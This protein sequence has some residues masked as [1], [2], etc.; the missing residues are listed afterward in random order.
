MYFALSFLQ[1]VLVN[2][3]ALFRKKMLECGEPVQLLLQRQVS[4]YVFLN[5]F[6]TWSAIAKMNWLEHEWEILL[7]LQETTHSSP[8]RVSYGMSSV[9]ML[10]TIN[11]DDVWYQ[12][13]IQRSEWKLCFCSSTDI[14]S[15][16]LFIDYPCH[17]TQNILRNQGHGY[18]YW[19]QPSDALLQP[20][21]PVS[22][23]CYVHSN[24][25]RVT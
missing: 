2:Q 24:S 23:E 3:S 7:N 25:I 13:L 1:T 18:I 5:L 20:L 8:S 19:H 10:E 6:K 21:P 9:S 22:A 4:Y 17:S 12:D 16:C 15:W 14:V 11:H